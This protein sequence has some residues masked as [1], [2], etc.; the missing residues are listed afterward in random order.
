MIGAVG[1]TVAGIA[2]KV[3]GF[4]GLSPAVEGPLSGGG[5]PEI[6][7]QHFAA[8][9]AR[10]MLSGL[11][12]VGSAAHRIA[13]AAGISPSGA[14]GVA[15]PGGGTL[16]LQVTGGGSGLDQLFMTWL[17]NNVRANGGDPAMFNRKVAFI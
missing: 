10:G 17:K 13:G 3:A 14:G 6:R 8:D 11:P 15:G 9:I 5:A 7:G 2:R 16:Q 4:F 12:S 1:N